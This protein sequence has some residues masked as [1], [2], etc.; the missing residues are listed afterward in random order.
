MAYFTVDFIDYFKELSANNNREWFNDN[1]KRYENSVK[2]PFNAFVQE[3]IDQMQ[4]DDHRVVITPRDA[5]FRINRDI[6]F[7]ADKTPYKTHMSAVISAGGKKS[8]SKPGVYVQFG[9]EDARIYSGAYELDKTQLYAVRETIAANPDTFAQLLEDKAFK[10]K[11]GAVHGAEHKRLPKEF[12]EAAE[13]QPLIYKKSFYY[14]DT[15]S[16][17]FILKKNLPELVMDYYF[18]G[19]PLG[20]FFANAMGIN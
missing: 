4:A 16:P 12:Q 3:M 2:K 10:K 13:K 1:K 11:F 6:R 19:K 5:I 15:L 17:E 7:S 20:E 14:F 9:A 18:A 8:K